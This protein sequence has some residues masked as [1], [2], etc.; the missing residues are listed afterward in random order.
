MEGQLDYGAM[1]YDAEIGRWNVAD[2]LADEFEHVSPYNYGMNN[3]I[4]MIDTDGMAVDIIRLGTIVIDVINSFSDF[5]RLYQIHQIADYYSRGSDGRKDHA[6]Y[7]A[8][9]LLLDKAT[10]GMADLIG[11][12]G[13]GGASSLRRAYSLRL[14]PFKFRLHK[15]SLPISK[16]GKILGRIRN[17]KIVLNGKANATGKFDYVVTKDGEILLG[18]KHTFMSGGQDVYAAGELK[19]RDGKIVEVNNLSGHYMPGAEDSNNFLGV[20]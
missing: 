7:A 8:M 14:S 11:A 4:L 6:G 19:L 3:P 12:R 10:G 1:F 18:R 2:P 20:F 16:V 9:T 5:Q 17:G 15:N 13:A